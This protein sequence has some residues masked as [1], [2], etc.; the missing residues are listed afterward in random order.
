[1][2]KA[3]NIVM[4]IFSTL[5]G[6]LLIAMGTIWVLQGLNIAFNGPMVGGHKSFMVGDN[7][8]TL[9]GVILALFGVGQVVWSNR[10]QSTR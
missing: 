9:Y 2:E 10:R 1:M 4:R 8:W 6:L 5:L 3:F 7:H